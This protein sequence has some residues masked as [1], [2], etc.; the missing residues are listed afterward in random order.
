VWRSDGAVA[1][2]ACFPSTEPPRR[3]YYPVYEL[4]P[5]LEEAE[6]TWL[7]DRQGIGPVEL[8]DV[9][10]ACEAFAVAADLR[11]AIGFPLGCVDAQ[12]NWVLEWC[13]GDGR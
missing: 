10:N 8:V 11:D 7:R 3:I 1:L 9:V 13:G 6:A 12:G 4:R 5:D 2:L